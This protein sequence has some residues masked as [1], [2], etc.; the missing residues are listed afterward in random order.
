MCLPFFD[1]PT[2]LS[3]LS[4]G[5]IYGS[6]SKIENMRMT[7]WSLFF[8]LLSGPL[9]AQNTQVPSI[10]EIRQEMEKL[11]VPA[12]VLYVAA[13]PDDENTRFIAWAANSRKVEAAYLS[14]TRGDG[15]Q[16]LIGTEKGPMLGLLRTNELLAARKIDRG[17]QFFT[18][19]NDF[20]Y[21]KSAEETLEIW[22]RDAVL[23]DM[24][25]VIRKYRPDVIVTRFPPARYGYR[26][27]GHHAASAILAEEAFRLAADPEAYSWQLGFVEPW[28]AKRLYWNTSTWFYRG[29][30]EK[31]DPRGKVMIDLGTYNSNLGR[32]MGEVAGM[33]RSQ[34]KSQGFGAAQ[35]MGRIEEWFEYVAGDSLVSE[36]PAEEGIRDKDLFDG[37]VCDWSR[38]PEGEELRQLLEK[39]LIEFDPES[40]EASLPVLLEAYRWMNAHSDAYWVARKLPDLENLIL[41][42]AAVYPAAHAGAPAAVP[43]DSLDIS[44]QVIVR[45]PVSV[46]LKEWALPDGQVE[47]VD[48]QLP[49]NRIYRQKI[50]MKLPQSL[51]YSHPYWLREPMDGIGM[52]R[53][54][55]PLLRTL[56]V[57]PP[58]LPVRFVFELDGEQISISKDLVYNYVDRVRGEVSD[59]FVVAPPATIT[60]D[61]R[62]LIFT[63][64][65]DEK[66][67]YLNIR[68]WKDSLSVQIEPKLT[69][70]WSYELPEPSLFL[71]KTGD[72]RSVKIKIKNLNATEEG[73]ME[74]HLRV[75]GKVYDR[76]YQEIDYEHI[77]K[78]SLFPESAARLIRI[79][80]DKGQKEM[81]IGYIMGAGDNVPEYLE[82]VGY[83]VVM[84][85]ESN[86]NHMD[87]S[88]LDAVML[89]IRALNTQK[90]LIPKWERLLRYA[91]EGG[92]LVV[93]YQTTWGLLLPGFAP[94]GLK[95]GKGRVT[96]ERAEMLRTN[97]SS[98]VL[99][100]PNLLNERDF[101]NW[102]QER[103]LYF[104][105]EWGREYETVFSMRDPGEKKALEGSLLIAPL[106]KGHFVYTGIGFFRQLPAGVPGAYRLLANIL[107][108]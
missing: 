48:E 9:M 79:D 95:L 102:V 29:S 16:N 17:E 65:L 64:A 19:A 14:L 50:A 42:C 99:T 5:Y 28:Q 97:P 8:L 4:I 27:H 18:R 59:P 30:G 83:H 72:E 13:H 76:A 101:E 94:Y 61:S 78:Q 68:A 86:F 35:T 10:A 24:V 25:W 15:G 84:I 43:G 73:A 51:R 60:A 63:P 90:W 106:G 38:I 36:A 41:M 105:S 57:N 62:Q 108:L 103:G 85:D 104:A 107:A 45:R 20:G 32:S 88:R 33:S 31:F 11:L 74:L 53:V 82:Q 69:E 34:H 77:P 56:P 98:R 70:G 1:I 46:Y 40:P 54:S 52:Y 67:V 96:D 47:E 75:N 44:L 12:S 91:E 81:N 58:A 23:E 66:E 21:S 37:V 71:E 55:N 49:F 6:F 26:T 7:L 87:W 89:G 92:T 22:D 80:L 3:E 93:Q 2:F 39:A 100:R